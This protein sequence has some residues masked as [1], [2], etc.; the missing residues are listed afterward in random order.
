MLSRFARPALLRPWWPAAA[1]GTA[2][3]CMSTRDDINKLRNIGISAHIDSGKVQ[4]LLRTFPSHACSI[5]TVPQQLS[6]LFWKLSVFHVLFIRN[7]SLCMRLSLG[8]R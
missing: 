6:C 5:A 3:R 2:I 7:T 8:I 4:P 1:S